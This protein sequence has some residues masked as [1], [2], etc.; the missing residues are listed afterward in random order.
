MNAIPDAPQQEETITARRRA[1]L[2][3]VRLGYFQ[4][5]YLS[6]QTTSSMDEERDEE[7]NRILTILSETIPS[8]FPPL[9]DHNDIPLVEHQQYISILTNIRHTHKDDIT[10][11]QTQQTFRHKTLHQLIYS[12]SIH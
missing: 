10:R 5:H 7:W 12:N 9:L 3:S 4:Q 6:T 11:L 8:T 1:F 2:Q